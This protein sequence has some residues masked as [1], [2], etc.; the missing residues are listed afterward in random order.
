M[1]YWLFSLSENFFFLFFLGKLFFCG[2]RK[3]AQTVKL[4]Y[5][6]R[7]ENILSIRSA[8]PNMEEKWSK[9]DPEHHSGERGRGSSINIFQITGIF[10]L[11][12]TWKLGKNTIFFNFSCEEKKN[13][14]FV[15][16]IECDL[17]YRMRCTNL[18]SVYE[19]LSQAD[20]QA[21]AYATVGLSPTQPNGLFYRK[22]MYIM[23]EQNVLKVMTISY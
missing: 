21:G 19:R 4:K 22:D 7:I 15:S 13:Y 3:W 8:S 2:C 5:W 17:F 18:S 6:E 23:H 12:Y 1:G 16:L 14:F 10:V 11:P 9:A 20:Y